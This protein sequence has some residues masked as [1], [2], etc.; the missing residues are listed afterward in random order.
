MNNC[1]ENKCPQCCKNNMMN[2]TYS[3]I[4]KYAG[5]RLIITVVSKTMLIIMAKQRNLD[6]K[7]LYVVTVEQ[8]NGRGELKG[9]QSFVQLLKNK[10]NKATYALDAEDCHHRVWDINSIGVPVQICGAYVTESRPQCCENYRFNSHNCITERQE[11][12]LIR[13]QFI[14]TKLI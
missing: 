7:P 9:K 8:R 10:P 11:V 3:E 6:P 1:A 5:E 2:M 12:R 4:E 13:S 14:D